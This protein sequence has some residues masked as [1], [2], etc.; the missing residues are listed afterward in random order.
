MSVISKL[1]VFLKVFGFSSR[2]F[3]YA[4]RGIP[5][6]IR[7]RSK[8]LNQIQAGYTEFSIT[9]YTPCLA[10]RFDQAGSISQH[11][12]YQDLL[13][14]QKIYQGKPVKH[15]DA[16]SRIDGFVAHVAS[17]REIEVM[18]IRPLGK[19]IKNVTFLQADLTDTNFQL[20]D[21]CDSLSCLHAIEHFGLGR[22]GDKVDINGHLKGLSNLTKMLR[23]GGKLYFSA[24]IGSQRIEFDAHR[25]FSL[26]Y[27]L[28]IITPAYQIA[29]F[30]YVNDSNEL[31]LN[32]DL[33][34]EDIA[35][36][37]RCRYGCGIFE[38]VK[39]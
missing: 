21:Y 7:N 11:Y 20:E 5:T 19:S 1:N 22:Y 10:D 39:L 32:V 35:T 2:T 33:T 30:S 29:S 25:V 24:P 4:L 37:L 12:F 14:A 31:V 38:L 36:N 16:G 15:V 17:F 28:N 6:Y 23:Q 18:D 9:N 34:S 8:L 3:F 26:E 13:I 27:L